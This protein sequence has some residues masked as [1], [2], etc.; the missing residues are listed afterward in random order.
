MTQCPST[1]YQINK[2]CNA[3]LFSHQMKRVLI[4]VITHC[5]SEMTTL[6]KRNQEQKAAY[7]IIPFM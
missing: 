1:G 2:T 6:M 3:M 7:C 5:S 4:H